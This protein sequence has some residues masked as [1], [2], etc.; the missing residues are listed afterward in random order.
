MLS[1]NEKVLD[2]LA[3]VHVTQRYLNASTRTVSCEYVFPMDAGAAVHRLAITVGDRTIEG[4]V[5]EA[6]AARATFTT[7]CHAGHQAAMLSQSAHSTDVFKVGHTPHW[8]LSWVV[9]Q[10]T[11]HTRGLARRHRTPCCRLLSFKLTLLA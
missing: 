10:C 5:M 3:Q 2:F 8:Q 7:A 11:T 1:L 6:G 4:R 9:L